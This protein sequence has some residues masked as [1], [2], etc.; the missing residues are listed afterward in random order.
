VPGLLHSVKLLGNEVR[1]VV[2]DHLYLAALETRQAGE[3]L[4]R[5]VAMGLIAALLLFSAW[6]VLIGAI[7]MMLVQ[8]S[9]LTSSSALIL[10]F[11]IHSLL[12]VFIAAAI[13]KRSKHQL[14]PATIRS[15]ESVTADSH[16]A[17]SK[18]EPT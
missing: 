1:G 5:I 13:R 9:L 18:I 17:P 2:H 15:S 3:G 12:V 7:V 6:L 11:L 16:A 10:V 4:V 8:R 14:F